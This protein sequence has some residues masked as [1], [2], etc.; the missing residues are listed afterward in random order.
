LA[1]TTSL[2]FMWWTCRWGGRN[3]N[4]RSRGLCRPVGGAMD[5][6]LS[7]AETRALRLITEVESEICHSRLPG[8]H[9]ECRAGAR[10]RSG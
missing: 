7:P 4:D 8:P 1:G 2:K 10:G 5:D 6:A 3:R 9:A